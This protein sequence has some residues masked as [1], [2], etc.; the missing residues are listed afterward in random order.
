MSEV[1]KSYGEFVDEFNAAD[2][3]RIGRVVQN[4]EMGPMGAYVIERYEFADGRIVR[5][6]YEMGGGS[7]VI[8][9]EKETLE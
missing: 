1:R 2:K 4:E 5:F 8:E 6:E 7:F 9:K 3:R